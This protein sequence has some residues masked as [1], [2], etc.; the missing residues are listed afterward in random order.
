MAN[1]FCN[2]VPPSWNRLKEYLLL[3]GSWFVIMAYVAGTK[4]SKFLSDAQTMKNLF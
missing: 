3:N 4:L 1:H 2:R